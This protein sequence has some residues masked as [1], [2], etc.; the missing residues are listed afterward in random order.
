MPNQ[1]ID[2]FHLTAKVKCTEGWYVGLREI[3]V[4]SPVGRANEPF[5]QDVACCLDG[6]SMDQG[7]GVMC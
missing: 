1:E 7:P 6:G 2:P 4:V 3:F 5:Q